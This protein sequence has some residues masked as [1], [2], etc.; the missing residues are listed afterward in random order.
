MEMTPDSEI[1]PRTPFDR[2]GRVFAWTTMRS[3]GEACASCWSPMG[4]ASPGSQGP[5]AKRSG[6]LVRLNQ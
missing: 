2:P 1:R 6:N 5:R 4:S 3:S